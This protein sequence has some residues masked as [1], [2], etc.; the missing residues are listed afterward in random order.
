MGKI[1]E[2]LDHVRQEQEN[3]PAA[4][5]MVAAY[6]VENYHQIPFLSISTLAQKIG[7]SDNTVVKF[8]NHLGFS[9]FAEFKQ[10]FADY[11]HSELVMFNMLE[12]NEGALDDDNSFFAQGLEDDMNA[13]RATLTDTGNR[14]KLPELLEMINRAEHI[15][16]TG[17]RGSA[18]MAGLLASTLRYLDLRVHEVTSG[19]GNY[20]DQL[21]VIGK[22]DLVIVLSFPRYT[23]QV[24]EG[25]RYLHEQGI[26]VALITDTGLS[27]AQPYADLAFHCKVL[28]GYYFPC[29]A[30]CLSLISVICRAAGSVR[31][32]G[33]AEHVRQLE[34]QLLERGI[35][36]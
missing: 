2:L 20:L 28:S 30:G 36:L 3:F 19:L 10:I 14:E 7:V 1:Q 13:I 27:P 32:K 21:S 31:K 17:G 29:Y 22:D 6:V 8:C 25:V 4:Q 33:A 23:A 18:Y 11:A 12:K 24:V 26:P 9:K 16:V 35:F 5:R 15:Y 34:S